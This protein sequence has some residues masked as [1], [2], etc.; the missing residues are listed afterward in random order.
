[1][2]TEH[3]FFTPYGS[4]GKVIG[5]QKL[6]R[7]GMIWI[8][9]VPGLR[10]KVAL[11]RPREVAVAYTVAAALMPSSGAAGLNIFIKNTNELF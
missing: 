5:P 10:W 8:S 3:W 4:L 9:K 11:A 1:M 7:S 6:P 2:A